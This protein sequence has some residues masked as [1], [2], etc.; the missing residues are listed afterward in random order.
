MIC[1]D[2]S[3]F[4]CPLYVAQKRGDGG[5]DWG[6]TTERAKALDMS[7]RMAAIFMNEG[8]PKRDSWLS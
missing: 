4:L 5:K 1:A 6:Y 3:R 2:V 8:V 7:P